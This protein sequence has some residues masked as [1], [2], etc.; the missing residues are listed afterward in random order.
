MSEIVHIRKTFLS[1]TI[2]RLILIRVIRDHKGNK[3]LLHNI[4]AFSRLEFKSTR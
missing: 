2:P 4:V 1:H 3:A